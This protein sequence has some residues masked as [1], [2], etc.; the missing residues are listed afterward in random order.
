ML[1]QGSA[2]VADALIGM[3]GVEDLEDHIVA[4]FELFNGGV[5]LIFGSCGLLVDVGNDEA[6]FQPL[7]VGKG[8]GADRLDEHAGAMELGGGCGGDLADYDAQLGFAGVA[9]LVRS[10][11]RPA[12]APRLAK[13]LSRSPMVTVVSPGL[14][15]RR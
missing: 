7:E 1:L 9:L 11:S 2:D 4:C 13:T 5:P 14:P 15:S 12:A 3:A 8:T 6:G 10:G